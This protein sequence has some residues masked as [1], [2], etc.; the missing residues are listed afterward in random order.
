[1][2][3]LIPGLHLGWPAFS[4]AIVGEIFVIASLLSLYRLRRSQPRAFRDSLFLI[5]FAVVFLIQLIA[6]IELTGDPENVGDVRTLAILVIVCF[7]GGVSRSW[8]LI[9]GPSIGLRGEVVAGLRSHGPKD[10]GA[11]E[12]E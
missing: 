5:G 2:F 12:D 11:E 8:D 1:M 7:L 10:G 3:A 4:I 9:G 6:G